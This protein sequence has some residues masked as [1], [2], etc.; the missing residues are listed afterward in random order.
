LERLDNS[1]MAPRVSGLW[2]DNAGI[3]EYDPEQPAA[4]RFGK[5]RSASAWDGIYFGSVAFKGQRP[6]G[7]LAYVA[8]VATRYC[9]VITTS[10]P[11]T[12]IAASPDKVKSMRSVIG[13]HPLAL[14]SGITA[15]NVEDFLPY[16]D[17]ALVATG[18]S[19]NNSFYELDS[20]RVF[21]LAEKMHSWT[22]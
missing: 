14:A 17:C 10:G 11:G 19:F 21:V 2:L 22:P 5:W 9:D 1:D 7:D 18:I 16:I 6:V 12:G 13:N 8:E 3:S 4:E 15:E 20:E